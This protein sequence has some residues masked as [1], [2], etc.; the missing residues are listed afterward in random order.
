M[1]VATSAIQGLG[2]QRRT[3]RYPTKLGVGNLGSI[4]SGLLSHAA[5]DVL[6]GETTAFLLA[7]GL[8]REKL[9]K[10]LRTQA[11]RVASGARLHR[12]RAER[13]IREG[14]ESLVEIAGVVHDWHRQRRYTDK[15]GDPLPLRSPILRRLIARRF[16]PKK[17]ASALLWMQAN[18]VVT[19]RRDG[20]FVPS[21]GRQVVLRGRRKRA[22]ER[23]AALVPQYLRI[24]LRNARTPDTRDR[25]V[26]RDARV[27]FL[28]QKYVRLWRAVALERTRSFLEGLDNWLEDHTQPTD[29]G[30][31]VEAAV[32]SYCYTGEPRSV[33][34]GSTNIARL[35]GRVA[36]P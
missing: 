4:G 6:L 19:R 16:P 34:H 24:A 23:T 14:H 26:D 2:T 33:K 1:K 35:E 7:A 28:P 5:L 13:V 18:G 3:G 11:R 25:D 10:E 15:N 27:F 17:V 9:V 12:P 31:T 20:L 36:R 8:S 22:V 30:P 29:C 32:H 21:M